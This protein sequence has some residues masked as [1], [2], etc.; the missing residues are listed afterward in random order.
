MITSGTEGGKQSERHCELKDS[1]V[2]MN[3]KMCLQSNPDG[4]YEI[5]NQNNR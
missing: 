4:Y 1:L 2:S 3:D 5:R